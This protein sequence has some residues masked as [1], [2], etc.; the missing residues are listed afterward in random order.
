M[1]SLKDNV[2]D[3]VLDILLKSEK[4]QYSKQDFFHEIN[5]CNNRKVS[6]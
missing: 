2:D 1:T 5:L 3:E 4:S 6:S